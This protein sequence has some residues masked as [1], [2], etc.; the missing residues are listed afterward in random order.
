LRNFCTGESTTRRR[1]LRFAHGTDSRSRWLEAQGHARSGKDRF[2]FRLRRL[3]LDDRRRGT[4]AAPSLLFLHPR[5]LRPGYRGA[6]CA[7][8]RSTNRTKLGSRNLMVELG[9]HPS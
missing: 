3:K 8:E 1:S 9:P 4:H 7:R 2:W 6:L 5:V